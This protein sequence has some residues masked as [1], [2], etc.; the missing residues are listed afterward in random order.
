MFKALEFD[1]LPSRSPLGEPWPLWVVTAHGNRLH[2]AIHLDTL[3]HF[4]DGVWWGS[5]GGRTL[6]GHE[7]HLAY[8]GV[9][10]RL[11][12]QRCAR[13]CRRLGIPRGTGHPKNDLTLRRLFGYPETTVAEG[14]PKARSV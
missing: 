7:G 11:G 10:T 2:V 9:L 14:S 3:E 12:M 5:G 6:C 4:D 8:P 1:A 13:C